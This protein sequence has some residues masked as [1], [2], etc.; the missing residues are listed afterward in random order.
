MR[1]Q[2]LILFACL[3]ALAGCNGKPSLLAIP[4]TVHCIPQAKWPEL[5]ASARLYGSQQGLKLIGGTDMIPLSNKDVPMLNVALAQG[6]NYYFGDDMDLWITSRP[7]EPGVVDFAAVVKQP[8]TRQQ[9]ILASA[10][11]DRLNAIAPQARRES[12][13]AIC[14]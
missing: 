9:R 11:L 3:L 8:A 12:Q 10:F 4:Q 1:G 13:H 5:I 6:Y 14:T 2:S 7:T